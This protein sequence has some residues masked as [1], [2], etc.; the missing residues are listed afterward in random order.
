LKTE[1]HFVGSFDVGDWVFF[2]FREN[3]VEYINCGKNIYSRVAR[4]CKVRKTEGREGEDMKGESCKGKGFS[5]VDKRER[6]PGVE[7]KLARN[8]AVNVM[9]SKY[10]RGRGEKIR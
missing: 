4:I 6:R 8:A 9:Q 10:M 2:F 3:A 1:P 7:K 5:G